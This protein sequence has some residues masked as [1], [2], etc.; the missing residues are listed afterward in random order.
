MKNSALL[1][2]KLSKLVNKTIC[3]FLF[4]LA[5]GTA[6]TNYLSSGEYQE[7]MGMNEIVIV[8]TD[9][10]DTFESHLGDVILIRLEE[11]PSTGY[12]WNVIKINEKILKPLDSEYL[13]ASTAALGS[14]GTRTFTFQPLS[15][16][17]TLVQLQLRREWESKN[18]AIEYFEVTIRVWE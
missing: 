12:Q 14:G 2:A 5:S 9:H 6:K 8:Q 18:G 11:N 16:G 3:L 1:I 10:G 13:E 4:A 15:P 7:S 17:T